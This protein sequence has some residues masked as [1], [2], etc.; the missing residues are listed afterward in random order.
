VAPQVEVPLH[1]RPACLLVAVSA[2]LQSFSFLPKICCHAQEIGYRRRSWAQAERRCRRR[3][4]KV[5]A[6]EITG[7]VCVLVLRT[8]MLSPV[9]PKGVVCGGVQMQ[10]SP[11]VRVCAMV[12]QQWKVGV[13]VWWQCVEAKGCGHSGGNVVEEV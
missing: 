5:V 10:Q 8:G 12:V 2:F 9:V 3:A 6:G 7:R 13:C 1:V 11:P 4:Q